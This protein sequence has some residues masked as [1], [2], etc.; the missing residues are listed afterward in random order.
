MSQPP[1]R[2]LRLR[3]DREALAGNWRA[4]D[5][6]SG[7]AAIT[8]VTPSSV[9]TRPRTSISRALITTL[10][11]LSIVSGQTTR[12][13]TPVSSSSVMNTTPLAEPGRW[14]ISTTPA[15]L[16]IERFLRTFRSPARTKPRAVSEARRKL[17]GWAFRLSRWVW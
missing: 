10:R 13:A 11:Y 15:R 17:I 2:S 5:R 1:P 7:S 8:W 4:L 12:L 3:L 14:R 6:L 16:I 9:S